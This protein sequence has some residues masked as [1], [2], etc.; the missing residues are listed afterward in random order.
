MKDAMHIYLPLHQ[1]GFIRRFPQLDYIA[2][3]TSNVQIFW[4]KHAMEITM[5]SIDHCRVKRLK[6]CVMV[7]L[8]HF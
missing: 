2:N 1:L 3:A 5:F 6:A 4:L 8:Y 7:D